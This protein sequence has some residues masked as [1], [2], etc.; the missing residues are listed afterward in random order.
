MPGGNQ[1]LPKQLVTNAEALAWVREA[2]YPLYTF[3]ST[4][5]FHGQLETGKLVSSKLVGGAA[6]NMTYINNYR[7]L[8]PLGTSLF[9][10]GD[11]MQ[12]TP[13]SNLLW[14]ESVIDVYN[15]MGYQA[16]TVGN[17][18]FDWGQATLQERMAQADFPIPA[19]QCLQ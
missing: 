9:D 11:I 15:H 7:A 5:D 13:I 8:N 10:A 2:R 17:H 16:A 1:I 12:G 6:Y 3:L 18:E 4:N 14:G 19:G